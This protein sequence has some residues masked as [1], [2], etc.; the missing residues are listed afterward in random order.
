I[1]TGDKLDL[2][3]PQTYNEKLQWL[4]LYY[5]N[6]K[7]PQCV[8]KYQVREYVRNKGL[9]YILN[10]LLW[11]GFNPEDIPFDDLPNKFVIKA[12][13]GQGYNIICT[14]KSKLNYSKTIKTL[15]KWLDTKF[16][17]SYGEWFYGVVKPR[18]IVEK[19]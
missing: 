19:F 10:D 9:D 14:D 5:K 12:T 18:I 8:D 2:K 11:E 16:L 15:N 13:H 6:P 3:H 4:K 17:P 7:I 1:K